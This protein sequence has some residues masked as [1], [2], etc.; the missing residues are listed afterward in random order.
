MV[1][2]ASP[3]VAGDGAAT[4]GPEPALASSFPPFELDVEAAIQLAQVDPT[5]GGD[6]D[7]EDDKKR[8]DPEVSPVDTGGPS[9][10]KAIL[11]SALLPGMGQL[12]AGDKTMGTIFLIGEAVCWTSYAT[13]QVQGSQREDRYI[14]YAERF[15]GVG[16]ASGQSSSYYG[17]LARYD[18]S[19]EPGGPESYNEIEVRLRAREL[20][21]DDQAQQAEYI[22]ENEIT[23][24][25]AWDWESDDRRYDYADIR[26][27]SE[28][29]YHRANYAVA[30][31]VVNR[32]LSVLHAVWLTADEE[33]PAAD[34][35]VKRTARP[36][37]DSDF[38]LGSSR[39]GV[40]YTF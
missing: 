30:G 22:R 37:A 23:G 35:G 34:S 18:R 31:L 17:S 5:R 15:A 20:Y 19:G 36:F 6:Q 10:A 40:R 24:E 1:A 16:D 8:P 7:D 12:Y 14:Q 21:P 3:S 29:A 32:I 27:S 39:L 26:I 28:T 2:A 25:Q 13:F 33:E 38:A 11:Y 4:S 9:R